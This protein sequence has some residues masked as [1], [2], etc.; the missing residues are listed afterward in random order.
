MITTMSKRFSQGMV[1]ERSI[2]ASG[3][4]Q[5]LR[6]AT[7]ILLLLFVGVRPFRAEVPNGHDVPASTWAIQPVAKD[8]GATSP[9]GKNEYTIWG[10]GSFHSSTLVGK[11]EDARL[12][13]V[14]L[15][16]ARIVKVWDKTI[17]KYTLDAVPVVVL[18][19]PRI[20]L[21]RTGPGDFVAKQE[22]PSIYGAGL[23]P[24]GVQLNFRSHQ[25]VQPFFEASG[26]FAYMTEPVPD[27]LGKQFNFTL[28]LRGGVQI[29][30]GPHRAVTLGYRYHHLSNGY[31]GQVNPGFDT[32]VFY[33][34]FSILR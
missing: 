24:L 33:V 17:L 14:G 31:R 9:G 8:A 12:R 5:V 19:F 13:T 4:R 15:R 23:A 11:V 30:T 20:E 22:R 1:I 32:N 2:E 3:H 25:L 27:S 29:F 10:G 18:S 16:Y 6:S 7:Q 21:A 26:G 28:D 34:G